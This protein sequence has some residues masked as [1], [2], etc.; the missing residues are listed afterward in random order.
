ML[1]MKKSF[2]DFKTSIFIFLSILVLNGHLASAAVNCADY[3][4]QIENPQNRDSI[5][6]LLC[7]LQAA[8]NIGLFFVGAVLVIL[9]LYGAI[10]AVT[11][12]GDPKQLEGA[13]MTWSYA[14]FGFI[15]IVFSITIIIISARLLGSNTNPLNIAD[16]IDG[17][18][19]GF[20]NDLEKLWPFGNAGP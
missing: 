6:Y 1:S 19:E 4:N 7:P 12:V 18:F 20:Y 15:I 16:S 11:A 10:K 17:T 9:V 8:I 2:R 13:K 5:L 14:I 3:K